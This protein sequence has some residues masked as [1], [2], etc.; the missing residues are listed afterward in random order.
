MLGGGG[1]AD[2]L[3]RFAMT[4]PGPV[5]VCHLAARVCV[6]VLVQCVCVARVWC[7]LR[8]RVWCC[9]HASR[10]HRGDWTPLGRRSAWRDDPGGV[11][12]GPSERCKRCSRPLAH[13]DSCTSAGCLSLSPPGTPC[14]C[15]SWLAVCSGGIA[16]QAPP[17]CL[18][19][20]AAVKGGG[21]GALEKGTSGQQA[22]ASKSRARR[23]WSHCQRRHAF[24]KRMNQHP[25]LRACQGCV[26]VR[27]H[28]LL[29]MR[30]ESSRISS[31]KRS[32]PRGR[33]GAGGRL[34]TGRAFHSIPVHRCLAQRTRERGNQMASDAGLQKG[35]ALGP[36]G[37]TDPCPSVVRLA[38]TPAAPRRKRAR[39]S[40]PKQYGAARK[41]PGGRR[42]P[43]LSSSVPSPPPP[44]HALPSPPH[45]MAVLCTRWRLLRTPPA[46][47]P[48]IR[49]FRQAQQRNARPTSASTP[50]SSPPPPPE[51]PPP[52][53][54]QPL[55]AG[56]RRRRRRRSHFCVR[57]GRRAARLAQRAPLLRAGRRR[58]RVGWRGRRQRRA[59][60]M[61]RVRRRA[62]GAWGGGGRV[63]RGWRR[64][65]RVRRRGRRAGRVRRRR[66]RPRDVHPLEGE[67]GEHVLQR[68]PPDAHL[69]VPAAVR[70]HHLC[71][72]QQ[73]QARRR[74][75][76]HVSSAGR[77][78]RALYRAPN[79][80]TFPVL[81]LL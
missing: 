58:R 11:V 45:R 80:C 62:W 3:A 52:V 35:A 25:G 1:A 48:A 31:R 39:R 44:S 41:A 17:A 9:C 49:Q 81:L 22:A 60:R 13:H 74:A 8:V 29:G 76:H 67:G 47:G 69:P 2:A 15:L 23:A 33:T 14:C 63:R 59:G 42:L 77:A 54:R 46:E 37:P 24:K 50:S 73:M 57:V 70:H 30:G 79:V 18:W 5:S 38:P 32:S 36:A 27:V 34:P 65:R 71:A 78:G 10:R 64:A 7:R 68:R 16:M 19:R 20:G 12:Y 56:N 28:A 40:A 6:R 61:R 26:Q 51:K 21:P 43:D 53:P 75:D 66:R 4:K 72:A 55:L